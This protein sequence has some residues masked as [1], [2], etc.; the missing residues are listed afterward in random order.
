[1]KPFGRAIVAFL[2]ASGITTIIFPEMV[3]C[4]NEGNSGG[5]SS[6]DKDSSG[7]SSSEERSTANP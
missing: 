7:L 1:M 5:E 2:L 3:S 6:A 4:E